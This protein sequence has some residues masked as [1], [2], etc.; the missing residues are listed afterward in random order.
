LCFADFERT[1]KLIE[2]IILNDV[3]QIRELVA[4]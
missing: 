4:S 1:V 2:F 3:K